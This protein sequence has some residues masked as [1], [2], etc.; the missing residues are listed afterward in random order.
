M[1][2]CWSNALIHERLSPGRSAARAPI[3]TSHHV[4]IFRWPISPIAANDPDS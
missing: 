4:S 1:E 2:C 3:S